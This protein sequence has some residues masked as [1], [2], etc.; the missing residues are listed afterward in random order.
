MAIADME[1]NDF[2]TEEDRKLKLRTLEIYNKRM[3]E[4]ERRRDLL[5]SHNLIKV[6]WDQAQEK[7]LNPQV[8]LL[9]F[10]INLALVLALLRVK[11]ILKLYPG[12]G[13]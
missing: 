13:F 1:F 2:D 7:R 10:I 11:R 6:K 12:L 9:A 8:S 5:L 3:D 4:R